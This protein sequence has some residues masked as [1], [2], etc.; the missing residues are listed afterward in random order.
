MDTEFTGE[1]QE[2]KNFIYRFFQY[3]YLDRNPVKVLEMVDD[4]ALCIGLGS[5][6]LGTDKKSFAAYMCEQMLDVT[7][8]LP[9]QVLDYVQYPAGDGAWVCFA[10]V[11]VRVSMTGQ[12][13]VLYHLRMTFTVHRAGEEFLFSHI[14]VS[15]SS[16]TRSD[17]DLGSIRNRNM[18]A[19]SAKIQKDLNKLIGQMLPGGVVCCYLEEGYPLALANEAMVTAGGYSSFRQFYKVCGGK[20]LNAVHPEDRARYEY[21]LNFVGKTGKQCESEYRL[22]R[23]DGN[24]GWLHDVAG[25]TV[26]EDGRTMIISAVY[27][28]SDQVSRWEK[29]EL[30]NGVDA[31]TGAYN[32]KGARKRISETGAKAENWCFFVA[33]LDNFKRVN[34]H[35]GHKQGDQVLCIIADLLKKEF[36]EEGTVIRLGGDEFALYLHDY[37]DLDLISYRLHAVVDRYETLLSEI[38]PRAE[39]SLSVGGVYGT[40]PKEMDVMYELADANLYHVKHRGKGAVLLTAWDQTRQ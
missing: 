8:P 21:N 2:V 23:R 1:S 31:L 33:D 12:G 13:K 36:G 24:Y 28:I 17:V 22:L 30:E 27:D 20:Y 14:H 38:C 29:L 3:Y 4:R 6:E 37:R 25:R 15:E 39:S 40:V 5:D 18:T 9:Y 11:E 34:D 19:S 32:R 26:S 10:L 35:Y 7:R 16:D